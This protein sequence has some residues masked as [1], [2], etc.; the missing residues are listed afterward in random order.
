MPA[1]SVARKSLYTS[2]PLSSLLLYNG[3]T[4]LHYLLG[5]I[6]VMLGYRFSWAAY[7]LGSLYL[8][9]AFA[10]MYVLMPLVV[11]PNCVYCKLDDSLCISGLNVISKTFAPAGNIRD[12]PKRGEG[13]LCHNN[14]Y[15]AAKI[16]PIIAVIPALILN[17]SFS[18]LA[19]FLAVLGL[20]LFR[21]F[22][23]FPQIACVHCRAKNICPNAEA[24]G[25]GDK[26]PRFS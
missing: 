3:A 26:Q 24:M 25:L 12:F 11:C 10:Q 1:E 17:F 4:F 7:L 8:A 18:L 15:M 23:I 6:G 19:I 9:F 5:G 2:Y 16:L 21:I 22:V 20:L 14:L 13:L